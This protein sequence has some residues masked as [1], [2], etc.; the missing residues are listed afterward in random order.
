MPQA[1]R[2]IRSPAGGSECFRFE[3]LSI[4]NLVLRA[5]EKRDNMCIVHLCYQVCTLMLLGGCI[6]ESTKDLSVPARHSSLLYPRQS[7][8]KAG[9]PN[10]T[11][12]SPAQPGR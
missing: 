1:S 7:L 6:Q 5:A 12:P 8:P 3:S 4:I 2:Q 11:Q 9:Q 10:P